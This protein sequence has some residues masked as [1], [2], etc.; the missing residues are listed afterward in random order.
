MPARVALAIGALALTLAA[1]V[2]AKDDDHRF[3]VHSSTFQNNGTLPLITIDTYP[4]GG[5]NSCTVDGT[6]GGNESPEVSW[7]HAP[8]DTVSF[9]VVMYD[10]TAS[11]THWAMF[12]IPASTHMLPLNAGVSGSAYGEQVSNDFGDLSY[13]GPCPPP[14]LAPTTHEYVVTVYALNVRLNVPAHGA[15][16]PGAEALYHALLDAAQHDHI[17]ARASI[18]GLYSTAPGL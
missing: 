12:N 11:F 2:T 4:P 9:V 8:E 14:T 17:L 1:S 7:S 15:F 18:R 13:D 6:P 5:P 16:P 10:V 3:A